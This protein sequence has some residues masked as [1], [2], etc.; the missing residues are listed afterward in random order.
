MWTAR[1]RGLGGKWGRLFI[2]AV[3]AGIA[4]LSSAPASA[5]ERGGRTE[6]YEQDGR[7]GARHDH[8]RRDHDRRDYDRRDGRSDGVR[9][10]IDLRTGRTRVSERHSHRPRYEER[11]VKVWCEPVYRTVTEE[12]WVEPEF[13]VVQDRVWHNAVTRTEIQKTW[14]PD[15]YGRRWVTETDAT[16]KKVRKIVHVVV[17]PGHHVEKPIQVV[18]KP[19]HWDIVD[20]QELVADGYWKTVERQEL[21]RAGYWDWR[22]E[23]VK[24]ADGG[25]RED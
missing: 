8:D 13:R 9:V 3:A 1:N 11:R 24:V 4:G 14:V 20:R 17:K 6:S 25:F 21:V 7:D 12:V 10:D 19:G 16:G 23:R 22:T 15:K 18:V 5:D 2:L